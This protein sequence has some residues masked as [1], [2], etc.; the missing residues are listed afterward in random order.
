MEVRIRRFFALLLDGSVIAIFSIILDR[1][2][3]ETLISIQG[4]VFHCTSV[5]LFGESSS[6]FG[7]LSLLIYPHRHARGGKICIISP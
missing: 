5:R 7:L 6:L 3:A 4:A 2:G 1:E